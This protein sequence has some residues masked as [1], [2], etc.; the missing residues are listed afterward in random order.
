MPVAWRDD[1]SVCVVMASGGYP[2]AYTTG[3]PISG[4]DSLDA[5]VQVFHAGTR[6]DDEGRL[7]TS[8]GRVL[9]VVATAPTLAQARTKAYDNVARILFE[10]AHYR[11]DIGL[12]P[13]NDQA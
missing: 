8:G 12:E 4:L 9:S 5:G 13:D 7:V 1:A 11:R 2:G 3:L 6:L 10:G